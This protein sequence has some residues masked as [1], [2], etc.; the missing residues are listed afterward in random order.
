VQRCKPG[1]AEL[2]GI[3]SQIAE[4]HNDYQ[5]ARALIDGALDLARDFAAVHERCDEQNKRLAN[6]TFFTRIYLNENSQLTANT[7]A[8]FETILDETTKQQANA[9]ANR[10]TAS[11]KKSD[12]V[13]QDLFPQARVTT[14][15]IECARGDLNPHVLANTGT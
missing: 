4:H 12:V 8:P 13:T 15:L 10:H 6:Q 11:N 3:E 9:W 1:A 7:A 5:G 14:S 2:D